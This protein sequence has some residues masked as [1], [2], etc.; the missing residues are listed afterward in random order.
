MGMATPAQAATWIKKNVLDRINLIGMKRFNV[1]QNSQFGRG[2]KSRRNPPTMRNIAGRGV[3]H[4]TKGFKGE[5]K[6]SRR[7]NRT[8]SRA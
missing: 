1:E 5:R 4:A 6:T 2:T 8:T 7:G 3:L